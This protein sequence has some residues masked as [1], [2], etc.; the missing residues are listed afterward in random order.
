MTATIKR[1]WGGV[2]LARSRLLRACVVMGAAG[3]SQQT[4]GTPSNLQFR[5]FLKEVYHTSPL[6]YR[7]AFNSPPV[8]QV[9]NST[10]RL[11]YDTIFS[12][13]E[14]RGEIDSCR[15]DPM[16]QPA[17]A[18]T[19]SLYPLVEDSGWFVTQRLS[20]GDLVIHPDGQ[21]LFDAFYTLLDSV[22]PVFVL[23]RLLQLRADG[24]KAWHGV[25]GFVV[26]HS[27]IFPG[28]WL[29]S[30]QVEWEITTRPANQRPYSTLAHELG[31]VLLTELDDVAWADDSTP[32]IH[33]MT[34]IG[35]SKLER[36]SQTPTPGPTHLA[37]ADDINRRY[38]IISGI[39]DACT[40]ARANVT[41][42]RPVLPP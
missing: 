30:R 21:R 8:R 1:R 5:S 36:A 22:V 27:T 34:H 39:D 38:L 23:P 13:A 40:L 15:I 16:I 17:S 29:N 41:F 6:T 42:V 4:Q 11:W 24:T 2:L 35:T 9:W 12:G 26:N 10:P 18:I 31:H 14:Y 28:I 33:I 7:P 32:F 19:Q 20:S 3:C 25:T 37:Q